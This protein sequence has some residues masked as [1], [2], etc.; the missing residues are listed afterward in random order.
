MVEEMETWS[1]ICDSQGGVQSD[2]GIGYG[3]V[4]VNGE[5]D[6]ASRQCRD[7]WDD[8]EGENW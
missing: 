7:I 5:L 2:N 8:E 6:P 4:D 3:G 1:I